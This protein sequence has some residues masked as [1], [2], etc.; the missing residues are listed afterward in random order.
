MIIDPE[1]Y[2]YDGKIIKSKEDND[3]YFVSN[4]PINPQFTA[5]IIA[6]VKAAQSKYLLPMINLHSSFKNI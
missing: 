5:P 2:L 1:K 4:K 6:T 3:N